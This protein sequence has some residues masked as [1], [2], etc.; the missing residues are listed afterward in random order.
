[1]VDHMMQIGATG[2]PRIGVRPDTNA[3]PY[4]YFGRLKKLK[5]FL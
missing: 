5:M 3:R 1:M 2:A 4:S